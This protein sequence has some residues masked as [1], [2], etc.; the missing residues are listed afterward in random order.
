MKRQTMN[1]SM[2]SKLNLFLAACA[3]LV[4]VAQAQNESGLY[5]PLTLAPSDAAAS[6]ALASHVWSF[7][8]ESD[9][10]EVNATFLQ[11]FVSFTTK[12]ATTFTLNAESTYD[13]HLR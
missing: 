9:R 8:G 1:K 6:S 10:A 13:W 4:S 11:P 5:R 7:A 12:K 2:K 3:L